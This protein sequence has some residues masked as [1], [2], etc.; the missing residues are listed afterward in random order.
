LPQTVNL[1]CLVLP[2]VNNC[3]WP[4][5]GWPVFLL[6]IKHVLLNVHLKN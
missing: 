2:A 5:E 4:T 1:T 6:M 3:G